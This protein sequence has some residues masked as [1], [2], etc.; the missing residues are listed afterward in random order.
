V[1]TRARAR[2]AGASL[3]WA[4]DTAAAAALWASRRRD[5]PVIRPT[6]QLAI[7]VRK[8]GGRQSAAA[9]GMLARQHFSARDWFGP[10]GQRAWCS[11][12]AKHDCCEPTNAHTL[13]LCAEA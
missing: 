3:C 12:A 2:W 1:R 4:K 10:R 6:A 13:L 8:H 7:S 9:V 5:V 11:S